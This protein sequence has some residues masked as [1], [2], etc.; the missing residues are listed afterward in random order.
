MQSS[1]SSTPTYRSTSHSAS[2]PTVWQHIGQVWSKLVALIAVIQLVLVLFNISYIP[3]RSLYFEYTPAVVDAYDPIKGIELHPDTQLYLA[4]VDQLVE[5]VNPNHEVGNMQSLQLAPQPAEI[6][7]ILSNLQAQSIELV[8][9]N[10]FFGANQFGAYAKLKQRIQSHVGEISAKQALLKFWS[11]DYLN[12]AGWQSE[13]TYFDRAIRPM[14]EHNYL[15]MLDETGRFADRFWQIDLWFMALF[16]V[17]LLGRTLISSYRQPQVSWGD[18]ILRRWYDLIFFLPYWRWLRVLPVSVR[19]HQSRLFNMERVLAQVTHEPVSYVADR[20]SKFL[21]VRLVNQAQTSIEQG[22]AAR[23]LF[24]PSQYRQVSNIN[25]IDAITDRLIQLSIYRVLP[26]VQPDLEALLHHSLTEVITQ[27]DF[28]GAVQQFPGIGNLPNETIEQLAEYLAQGTYDVLKNA[29]SDQEGRM[30]M[31]QLSQDFRQA[32]KQQLQEK[33]TQKE[34]E[35][36]L[37]DLLEELKINYVEKSSIDNPEQTLDEVEQINQVLQKANTLP[38]TDSPI[39][40]AASAQTQDSKPFKDPEQIPD[41]LD[42]SQS[43]SE[44]D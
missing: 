35:T 1:T 37:I 17:D 7:P 2:Q 24:E 25:K 23:F 33:Q 20:V 21:M 42:F 9:E 38:P 29:Y 10:P 27:S 8:E 19:L 12:R 32:L 26:E 34:L 18:A 31:E 15:R 43:K 14:L 40:P 6:A 4:T 22:D 30:L 39:N 3:L 5:T 41:V 13:L 11:W 36:L 16:A 28:Y 44:M